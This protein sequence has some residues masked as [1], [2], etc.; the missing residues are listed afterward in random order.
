MRIFKKLIL[1]FSFRIIGRS[2]T[3]RVIRK[4]FNL[5]EI[6]AL[7]FAHESIG[8]G[9]IEN[10]IQKDE[11]NFLSSILKKIFYNNNIETPIIFDIG[12][13]IG[14]Y[15]L[16]IKQVFPHSKLYSFEPNPFTFNELNRNIK[17]IDSESNLFNIGF[18]ESA[19]EQILYTYKNDQT[20]EHAS[21]NKKVFQELYNVTDAKEI[22]VRIETLD[23]FCFKNNIN[24]VNFMKIDTEGHELMVLKGAK[25][26]IESNKIDIIQLEFN[27]MNSVNRIFLH[28]FYSILNEYSFFRI[29][30]KGL[31]S[32]G[33][34][35]VKNEI[36]GYQNIVAIKKNIKY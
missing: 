24:S 20:S 19:E 8:I 6:N 25:K 1:F 35:S 31:L 36:F 9:Y 16:A 7:D 10:K 13:N 30:S 28:D 34:Y 18:G 33:N 14:D 23:E 15:Y 5:L 21:L 11:L 17:Q 2:N 12:A 3:K 29:Y 32:L 22:N 4:I 27:E 26:L